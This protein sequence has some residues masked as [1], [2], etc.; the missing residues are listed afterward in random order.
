M[1]ECVRLFGERPIGES[2]TVGIHTVGMPT[3]AVTGWGTMKTPSFHV[4]IS[5]EI[6]MDKNPRV[7]G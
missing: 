4:A 1:W 6:R 5:G 2:W 3:G 7:G